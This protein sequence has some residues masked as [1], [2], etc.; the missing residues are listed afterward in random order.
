MTNLSELVGGDLISL[1]VNASAAELNHM[2]GVT[3]AVQT[4]ISSNLRKHKYIL[5]ILIK[6]IWIYIF[7]DEFLILDYLIRESDYKYE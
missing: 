1:G 6:N 3:S 2:V 7:L 4:Q 5:N